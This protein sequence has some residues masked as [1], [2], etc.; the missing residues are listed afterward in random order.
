MKEYWGTS[1]SPIFDSED[2]YGDAST[3]TSTQKKDL[4]FYSRK[5]EEREDIQIH[6]DDRK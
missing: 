4:K 3:T 5:N 2:K 6:T 1:V